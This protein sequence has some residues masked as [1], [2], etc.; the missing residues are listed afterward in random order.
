MGRNRILPGEQKQRN[1]MFTR[2]LIWCSACKQFKI[3]EKFYKKNGPQQV[4]NY[5]YTFHCIEC[6]KARRNKVRVNERTKGKNRQLKKQFIDLAGGCCQRCGYNEFISALEFHHVYPSEKRA[7]PT[8]VI[9]KNNFNK[10]WE[11]LD[12]C[13]LLCSICHKAYTGSEWRAEFVKRNGLGWTVGQSFSLNDNRY[14]RKS[15]QIQQ[16]SMPIQPI[17]TENIQLSLIN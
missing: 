7:T 10:T 3:I 16:A 9:Y 1:E 13:C 4:T 11:E 12:K 6:Y 8:V 2:G 5:G 15:E 14:S 17:K